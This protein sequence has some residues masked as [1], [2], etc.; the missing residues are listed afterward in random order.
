[1]HASWGRDA[2]M[3]FVAAALAVVTAHEAI[4]YVLV[5]YA[6][7]LP[8][9]VRA[10]NM[11]SFGPL[12]VPTIVNSMFWGGL[13]GVLF[14]LIYGMVPGGA[15]WLKGLI[16][17]LC[18]PLVSNWTLLPLIRRALGVTNPGQ[19]VMFAG[20]DSKRLLAVLLILGGFGLMLGILYGLLNKK[21]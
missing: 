4:V 14:A 16:F 8:S 5:N 3:G 2:I 15:P 10:W 11:A 21:A 1:M 17:G 7:L 19:S 9:A 13:W 12:G 20:G 6:G 18:I